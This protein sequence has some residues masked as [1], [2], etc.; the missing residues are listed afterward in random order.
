[1]SIL[2]KDEFWLRRDY[3]VIY[4]CPPHIMSQ[5]DIAKN[6]MLQFGIAISSR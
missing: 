1:M 6:S 2:V 4:W 3:K 5:C